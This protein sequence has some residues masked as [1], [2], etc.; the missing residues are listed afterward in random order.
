MPSTT[1]RRYCANGFFIFLLQLERAQA[2]QHQERAHDPEADDDLVFMPARE[3]E[4]MVKRRHLEHAPP[5]QLERR[6]L[7]HHA[8]RFGHEE[9]ADDD[10]QELALE[11][12]R[13]DAERSAQ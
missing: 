3:L 1:K 13:D 5:R 11:Q 2:E 10:E 4:M 12:H 9:S 8:D 7:D 6:D